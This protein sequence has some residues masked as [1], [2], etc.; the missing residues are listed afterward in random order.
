MVEIYGVYVNLVLVDY[1]C[2]VKL[3]GC[4]VVFV[5]ELV[6]GIFCGMGIWDCIIE[7][8]FCWVFVKF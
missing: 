5:I 2:V 4:D 1:L 6:D 7:V 8:V 3:I